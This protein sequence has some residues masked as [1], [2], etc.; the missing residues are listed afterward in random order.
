MTNIGISAFNKCTALQEVTIPGTVQKVGDNAFTLCDALEKLVFKDGVKEIGDTAFQKLTNL[1]TIT[2][3]DGLEKIG[4]GA[5]LNDTGLESVDLKSAETMAWGVFKG[6]TGIKE[7]T[8]RSGVK[9]VGENCFLDAENV[10]KLTIEA[11]VEH[12][13][14]RAFQQLNK[15]E[16]VE[17]PSSIAVIEDGAFLSCENLE[18]ISLPATVKY[19]GSDSFEGTRWYNRLVRGTEKKETKD[20][21]TVKYTYGYDTTGKYIVVGNVLLSLANDFE[22]ANDTLDKLPEGVNVISSI[23]KWQTD[24][25][26][27]PEGITAIGNQSVATTVKKITL[28]DSVTYMGRNLFFGNKALEEIKLPKYIESIPNRTFYGCT[29]LK[30]IAIPEH[31]KMI[32]ESAFQGCTGLASVELPE[33]LT[34]IGNYAFKECSGIS[35]FTIPASVTYIGYDA[36]EE[37]GDVTIKGYTGS[38]AENYAKEYGYQFESIGVIDP[39][40]VATSTPT[41]TLEPKPTVPVVTEAPA[42]TP[43]GGAVTTGPAIDPDEEEP[44]AT[45][46]A[47]EEEPTEKPKATPEADEDKDKDKEDSDAEVTEK[48]DKDAEDSDA[49]ATEKP[50]KDAEDSAAEATEKPDKDAEDS[51]VKA[52]EKPEKTAAPDTDDEDS[53]ET[54]DED[55]EEPTETPDEDA[56]EAGA[57]EEIDWSKLVGVEKKGYVI[58]LDANGGTLEDHYV[59][60]INGDTYGSLPAPSKAGNLF[61][62]WYTER[63]D[64]T[65]M[66]NDTTVNLSSEQTLYAHWAPEKCVVSFN[67]NGGSVATSEATYQYGEVY[68]TLPE[69]NG[70]NKTFLGW[71]TEKEG[72][73]LI[74]EDMVVEMTGEVN[75]YAHWGDTFKAATE[76]SLTYGFGNTASSFN[77]PSGY[78]IPL[79]VYQY[80]YGNSQYAE[81][82]YETTSKWGG[83]C[84]GLSTTSIFFNT[85][86]NDVDLADFS[87]SATK[88]SELKVSD[89]NTE[90]RLSL[91]RFIE[92]MHVSQYDASVTAK[93][94]ENMGKLTELYKE[95]E[96]A[97]NEKGEPII[98]CLYGPQGGH[99]VVGYK[100]EKGT[101]K[102]A[103]GR[104]EGKISL[105]DPNFPQKD[106]R[107]IDVELD[108][109]GNVL[110][111]HYKINDTYDWSSDVQ[112]CS[113]SYIPY[114]TFYQMWEKNGTKTYDAMNMVT[115]NTQ[116]A[117]IYNADGVKVAT[118]ENGT[119]V[120]DVS[121]IT[122]VVDA[123]VTDES[124]TDGSV[125][126]FIPADKYS[127]ENTGSDNA[128]TMSV[129]G[130]DAVAQVETKSK[131]VT[132]NLDEIT[133]NNQVQIATEQGSAYT[134]NLQSMATNDKQDVVVTGTGTGKLVSVSQKQGDV[135]LKQC[136]NA[137]VKVNGSAVDCYDIT[138][139]AGEGGSISREGTVGTLSGEQVVYAFTPDYGYMVK[140]VVVDGVSQGNIDS[141]IFDN[142]K[143]AHNISVT[144][145]EA[146]ITKAYVYANVKGEDAELQ[147]C[148]G[149]KLLVEGADYK[150]VSKQV[151]GKNV[152]CTI[153][154]MSYFH[155]KLT[156][157]ADTTGKAPIP[158][159][160]P[161]SGSTVAPGQSTT[162]DTNGGEN[163]NGGSSNNGG[164]DHNGS[165]SNNG[166][167]NNNGS[168]NNNGSSNNNGAGNTTGATNTP[169]ASQS[170][171]PNQTTAPAT[172]TA[173]AGN[174]NAPAPVAPGQESGAV[175]VQQGETY[176]GDKLY[177]KVTN[178]SKKTVSVTKKAASGK[179]VTVPATVKIGG[180]TFKVT[181]IG[182]G[183]W[184]N[185]KKITSV[186]IGKNV[187][188]IGANAFSGAKNLKK[189]NVQSTVLKSVGSKAFKNISAKAVIKVPAKKKAAYKKLFKGKGQKKS[190]KIK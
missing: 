59:V 5:F 170:A 176:K 52:T 32:E 122:Q 15:L 61:L 182:S 75:L 105:Y 99:A 65:K 74:T 169:S 133:S 110:Y 123:Q 118:V 4:Y 45:P 10:E 68:G 165:N 161:N 107:Y 85:D 83:S 49:E 42:K 31:V 46:K 151:S 190:V 66:E 139:T 172:S 18:K 88:V 117:A 21:G 80:V 143:A 63:E 96:A 166:S 127:F 160:T 141:Y 142:V 189:I 87:K 147:V 43:T 119:L 37:C 97:Q 171:A 73:I 24:E 135:Q 64:G 183:V 180:E 55:T 36:F 53:T 167:S 89:S 16:E 148:I 71:Y 144:F 17:F 6:C 188:S 26:T 181:A 76:D 186:T 121:D 84:Y 50:H 137:T 146:D 39:E 174:T 163:N 104:Y 101:E 54:P 152:T 179:A 27:I 175:A 157:A 128:L 3:A 155:G 184:K 34:S 1:K 138:A 90:N 126:L 11:G 30:E 58:T 178:L 23:H 38:A 60:V 25:I 98:V 70:G 100:A 120:S 125:K 14:V 111:W 134:V 7:V 2:F 81:N 44:T 47:D 115:L 129:M 86:T 131:K 136:Q 158:T 103:N 72:G 77:Y 113:I 153:E 124:T 92:T 116:N 9:Q 67:A 79:S 29:G 130:T 150:V 62:G 108:N 177:Y 40:K 22:N 51:D 159:D 28:P 19:M 187:T 162:P 56:E 8:L 106:D 20:D 12:I 35:T 132:V 93:I 164:A 154:G 112:G 156:T 109:S 114:E 149:K 33:G 173:P 185:D 168:G 41:P 82:L 102:N 95:A 91:K 145:E 13:G 94:F 140:D 69:A 78:Q 57:S 48:P